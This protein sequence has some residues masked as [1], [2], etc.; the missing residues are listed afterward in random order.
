MTS[1]N[2]LSSIETSSVAMTS[3]KRNDNF[4]ALWKK[5]LNFVS[6]SLIM[7][8][9]IKT[10][11]VKSWRSVLFWLDSGDIIR[12]MKGVIDNALPNLSYSK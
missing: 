10:S 1:C 12:S 7:L 3:G 6:N 9:K 11:L 2:V 8:S 4:E 5:G